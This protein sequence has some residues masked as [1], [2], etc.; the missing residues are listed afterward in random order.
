MPELTAE[1]RERRRHG[2]GGSD[3]PVVFDQGFSSPFALW[4][5]KVWGREDW[6]SPFMQRGHDLEPIVMDKV[7]ARAGV[8]LAEGWWVDHP[9]VD[10]MFANLD[11]VTPDERPV[12]LK[13]IEH[14][15]KGHEWGDD[16]D[17][18]GVPLNYEIQTRHQMEC[19]DAD[20][21]IVGVLFV[22]LWEVR[23]Y[24]LK[25]DEQV[26]AMIVEG[27]R[28]FWEDHV[29]PKVMPPVTDGPSAWDALRELCARPDASVDL[30]DDA[31]DLISEWLAVR[32]ERLAATKHETELKAQLAAHLG[33]AEYGYL[34]GDPVVE[35]INRPG[36]N[37]SLKIPN[38]YQERFHH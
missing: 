33:D 36:R 26:A 37:R 10:H 18:E 19:F 38:P 35:F 12:E 28:R 14:R 6:T 17:P 34:D 20:E 29:I 7:A 4:A 16:G 9:T 13:V 11:A 5:E 31:A 15:F 27:E 23:V 21:A 30:P 8:A 24:E 22:D 25:R 1:I 3:A 2:I 32:A